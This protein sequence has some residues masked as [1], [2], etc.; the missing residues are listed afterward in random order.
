[1][2]TNSDVSPCIAA[3]SPKA[4]G[5]ALAGPIAPASKDACTASTRWWND[6]LSFTRASFQPS[7]AAAGRVMNR[8][9][10]SSGRS[11]PKWT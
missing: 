10:Y 11:I 3:H 6:A 9:R 1:L 2:A 4:T 8:I 7:G 5:T